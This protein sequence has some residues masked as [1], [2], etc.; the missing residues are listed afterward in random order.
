MSTLTVEK[1]KAKPSRKDLAIKLGVAQREAKELGIPAVIVIEGLDGSGKG[2][3]LNKLILELDARA[4]D[5]YST[6]AS[7]KPSR[8]Y[9]L[10]WRMWNH[11]PPGGKIQFFDRSAYYLVLNA[12]AD[13]ELKTDELDRYW[14][15][16]TRFERHLADNGTLLLKILLTVSKK[17][18]A[19]RFKK[20]AKNRK[21]AW[22]VT[23]KD[24]R[25]HAQYRD[26]LKQARAM[27]A[28]TETSFAPWTEIQTDDF[29]SAA[30]E[31]L[32]V[33]VAAFRKAVAKRK[34]ALRRPAPSRG[35]V[36]F[37]GTNHLGRIDLSATLERS[38]YKKLLRERQAEM[39]DLAH[40]IHEH[41]IPVVMAYCGWDAAGKGGCIKRLLQGIDP[42][43]FTVIPV[44]APN[45]VELSHHYLWRFWRVIPPKGKISILDRSWY[46]RVL[47]ERVEGFC[48]NTEWKRAYREI[49]ELEEHLTDFG[50][51]MIKFWLHLDQD[52]Q[53][54]RFEARQK[55]P[56][57]RWK[58]TDED[59][60]NREKADL[61]EQA[62]NEMIKRTDTPHAPWNIIASNCKMSARIQTL[63]TVIAA[64]K[65]AIKRRE[66]PVL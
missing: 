44:G 32:E 29:D 9:P 41:R 10:L 60:R 23:D 28:A 40:Q 37:K 5:I 50:T 3:L 19:K 2:L 16:I 48:T 65:K 54:A 18:Q 35:W 61:Y 46:G 15:D 51:V 31:I 17:E 62:V 26:Y 6:H 39:Y 57:K 34:R 1:E 38:Q 42:R 45:E 27:M 53:L 14:R 21:T 25:R 24:W 7:D 8:D 49:N 64:T 59:W 58:I 11:T 13:G 52:T 47:V 12:W 33:V 55:N 63:D 22:R 30:I 56:Y 36:P 66:R 20:L 4:Y 43:S